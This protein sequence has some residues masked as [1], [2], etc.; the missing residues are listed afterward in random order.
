MPNKKVLI[1]LLFLVILFSILVGCA[2]ST[3]VIS[4]SKSGSGSTPAPNTLTPQ[5]TA[6]PLA[7]CLPDQIKLTDIVSTEPNT[8]PLTVEQKLKELDAKC[9]SSGRL[10]DRVERQIYFYQLTGCWGNPP[11]D[12]LE[13]L[14]KQQE[15][16]TTLRQTFTVI[17]MTCN[18][19]GT[20]IP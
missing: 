5:V 16:L 7:M 9:S 6:N 15:E 4:D 10:I 13:I 20:P 1:Q 2:A 8:K 12:Y 17:E 19:T 18:P 11:R 14:K 3:P